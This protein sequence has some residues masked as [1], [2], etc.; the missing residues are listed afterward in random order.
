MSQLN[1]DTIKKA[2]GTGNLSVPAETGTVVTTASPSLGRRNIILNGSMQ[3]W[4]RGTSA[5]KGNAAGYFTADRWAADFNQDEGSGTASQT[6]E[7]STDV[8]AGSGLTY[9]LKYT[10]SNSGY[11]AGGND[12]V[13][14]FMYS[15]EAS[16]TDVLD[17]GS[18]DAKSSTLSF[19]IKCSESG[20]ATFQIRIYDSSVFSGESDA[21]IFLPIT[22]DQADTWE[23]KTITIPANTTD[24]YYRGSNK[25]SFSM[26]WN[27]G[28]NQG[29]T[30]ITTEVWGRLNN[31][32][33]THEDHTINLLENNG[34]VYI[35]GVQLE[36]GSVATPFEHRSYGEELALCKRY[37]NFVGE[38]TVLAGR[39]YGAANVLF[40]LDL[41]VPMRASPTPD[42]TGTART[43]G[44]S[45]YH[46]TNATDVAFFSMDI[47]SNSVN[48]SLDTFSGLTDNRIYNIA[49]IGSSTFT[50]DA[51]L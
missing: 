25:T 18:A 50:L 6:L 44:G 46:T 21:N 26:F 2:D 51:E 31:I 24:T 30:S 36:V 12:Y 35:T 10:S 19:W 20:T 48:L 32:G 16:A 13:F 27:F 14:P 41:T 8:P 38:H 49:L 45:N 29:A 4:Q 39:S 47:N 7:Q 9:S 28:T 34:T 40:S 33:T 1:V 37:Y 17:Y 15:T 22:I 5:S 3:V 42:G 23:Y 43:Y 11:T